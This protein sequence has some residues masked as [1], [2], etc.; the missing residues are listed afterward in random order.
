[1][2]SL[3]ASALD[4]LASTRGLASL[5]VI[6]ALT[7]GSAELLGT[8]WNQAPSRPTDTSF[9]DA[10]DTSHLIEQTSAIV[11]RVFTVDPAHPRATGQS[12]R[13]HLTAD[14]QAQF[15]ELYAPYLAKSVQEVALLTTTMGV[16]VV[17]QLDTTA[18]VLV[19][20]TQQ[21]SALDG[22]S[23]SG[24]AELRLRLTSDGSDWR[25]ASIEVV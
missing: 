6:L 24:T 10:S 1:M 21:A 7:L 23:N 17:S 12:I 16:G 8:G 22:R 9:L 11:D 5:A 2:S 3:V 14:A 15:R 19:V 4:R 18:E 13:A 20:A 25:I